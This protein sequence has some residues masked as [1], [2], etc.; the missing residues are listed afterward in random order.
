MVK[1]NETKDTAA[2]VTKR[3]ERRKAKL[4]KELK[5]SLTEISVIE[6]RKGIALIDE[7]LAH[8]KKDTI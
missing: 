3:M 2:E 8:I 5:D 7:D 6:T 1:I 4:Q